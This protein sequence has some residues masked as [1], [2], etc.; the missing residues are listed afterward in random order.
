MAALRTQESLAGKMMQD[1]LFGL[2]ICYFSSVSVDIVAV[3]DTA[4]KRCCKGIY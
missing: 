1:W 3:T 4:I 2:D